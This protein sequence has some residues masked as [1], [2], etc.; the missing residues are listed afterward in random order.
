VGISGAL[1]SLRRRHHLDLVVSAPIVQRRG[2][3]EFSDASGLRFYPRPK[4]LNYFW[5]GPA[6]LIRPRA[7]TVRTE[8][9]PRG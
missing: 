8:A 1:L 2:F 5:I 4:G 7:T 9:A 6:A 3:K